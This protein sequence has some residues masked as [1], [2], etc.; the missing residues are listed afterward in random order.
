MLS[1]SR[2][3]HDLKRGTAEEYRMLR[4]DN[5]AVWVRDI[6][7]VE[8]QADGR[9]VAYGVMLDVTESRRQTEALIQAQKM[10]I[11]GQMTGGVAHDF[12]NL[13]TV[14]IANLHM[15]MATAPADAA[16][17]R[18]LGMISQAAERSAD[19]TKR[20]LAFSRRQT[21]MPK[22]IDVNALVSGMTELLRRTL[23]E[24]IEIKLDLAS[25]LW[26]THVDPAQLESALVNLAVNARDAMSN[27]GTLDVKTSNQVL[28]ADP[29][30]SEKPSGAFV[31][32][33]V[34]DTG[35]GMTSATLAKVF[36]PFF[37]TKDVGKG[38]GLGL[39]MIYGFA[40]QSGGWIDV[41][42]DVGKGTVFKLYL[43]RAEGEAVKP[44]DRPAASS[45][46]S[47][48]EASETVLC[49]D[50]DPQVRSTVRELL[51]HLGLRGPRGRKRR[52]GA[53]GIASEQG[54]RAAAHGHRHARRHERRGAGQGGYAS[55]ARAQGSL[56]LGI[57]QGASRRGGH[58]VAETILPG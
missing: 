46:I 56:H 51:L 2:T 9:Y 1:V 28:H 38:T 4:T 11:V 26:Q 24:T 35:C 34:T 39:S 44:G 15:V 48:P 14:I 7:D 16:T 6:V 5:T 33:A 18:R 3:L 42:S 22:T 57:C 47:V 45:P 31:M 40:N 55:A 20:L 10:D 43:P 21:L 49:V 17:Q 32:L 8:Q 41:E 25:D 37:T 12:N 13:L 58:L 29:A 53:H 30:K 50:D 27:A 23:G 19:L 52:L 54:Y 36:E